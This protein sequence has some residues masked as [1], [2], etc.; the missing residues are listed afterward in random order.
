MPKTSPKNFW[1]SPV[2]MR[3]AIQIIVVGAFFPPVVWAQ[4]R[5]RHGGRARA[6]PH[7]PA[8]E[9]SDRPDFG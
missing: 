1:R 5:R 3:I 9:G 8:G 4:D 2:S 7:A 6:P